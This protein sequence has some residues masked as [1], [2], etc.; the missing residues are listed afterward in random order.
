MDQ[1]ET[2]PTVQKPIYLYA[3]LGRGCDT[4]CI[5]HKEFELHAC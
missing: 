5:I 3:K 1:K 4:P 2:K